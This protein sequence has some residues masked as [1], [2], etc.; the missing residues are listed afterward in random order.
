MSKRNYDRMG[1]TP[2]NLNEMINIK[3][4]GHET[5]HKEIKQNSV[6]NDMHKTE[7]FNA[8]SI[9]YHWL[10]DKL[11]DYIYNNYRF[12]PF[13]DSLIDE[14]V[15]P[16][17]N[18]CKWEITPS[19]DNLIW[20]RG[21]DWLDLSQRIS[22]ICHN[23]F[24]SNEEKYKKMFETMTLAFHPEWN[25]DGTTTT[26]RLLQKEGKEIDTLSGKDYYSKE[27]TE[28]TKEDGDEKLIKE[29]KEITD[30]DGD[31]KTEHR[32][33]LTTE[34]LGQ[35]DNTKNG[36]ETITQSKTAFNSG[37]IQNTQQEIHKYDDN[38]NH[39][40]KESKSFDD[41]QDKDT[42]NNDD[43]TL[44]NKTTTLEYDTR[45]DTTE[46]GKESTLSFED[47]QDVT[48]YGK[49]D[50]LEFEDRKDRET[51]T[52][53]RQGNIGVVST[54][55]LLEENWELGDFANFIKV[56]AEDLINAI[57]YRVY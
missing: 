57:C 1:R 38:N 53:V 29:G 51:T 5:T 22:D 15:D 6:L 27:G 9:W 8:P 7:W 19:S 43:K 55:K 10:D 12:R 39:N 28:T 56:V 13:L 16:F 34:Y 44:F 42:F 49:T 45:K 48:E 14:Y 35:E 47:R 23:V 32:G 2:H 3:Y 4:D 11:S 30:E 17:E 41:R 37:T 36:G 25:V 26:T 33:T 18:F 21:D 54:V 50:T 24:L 52:E 46:F 31:N 20:T 40:Y